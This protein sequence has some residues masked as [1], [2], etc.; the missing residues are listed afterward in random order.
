M[1]NTPV[2]VKRKKWPRKVLGE[3]ANFIEQFYPEGISLTDVARDLD[4]TPQAISNMFRRD[5]MKLSRAEE[6]AAK[7]G[8]E[9]KLYYPVR[10]YEDGYQPPPP[11]RSYPNAGNLSGLLKYMQD[12]DY[13]M[14]F[15]A[16]RSHLSTGVL[17]KAFEKG[18]ILLSTLYNILDNINLYVTW[19]Y[20]KTDNKNN[21]TN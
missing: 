4:T 15:V 6:I 8:Y 13:S 12:S 21:N 17:T 20:E 14:N 18:D 19:K 5:D 10:K 16:E 7:Y 11:R 1:P 2:K 3:L 9:L